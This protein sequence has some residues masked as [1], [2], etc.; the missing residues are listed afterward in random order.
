[1][2][3][4]NKTFISDTLVFSQTLFSLNNSPVFSTAHF[5]NSNGIRTRSKGLN[6]S[7]LRLKTTLGTGYQVEATHFNTGRTGRTLTGPFILYV[8]NPVFDKSDSKDQH[9][10]TGT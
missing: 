7:P 8:T 10:P 4:I 9:G 2:T 5:N 6:F 3:K 1:M